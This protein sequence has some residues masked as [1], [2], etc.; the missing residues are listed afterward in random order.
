MVRS[1][2]CFPRIV[3]KDFTQTSPHPP[4]RQRPGPFLPIM[5]RIIS[6]FGLLGSLYLTFLDELFFLGADAFE[7]Y[8]GGLVVRIL[9]NQFPMNGEVK[10]LLTQFLCIHYSSILAMSSFSFATASAIL[11]LS[12]SMEE[13]S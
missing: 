13:T 4:L 5:G 3:K 6:R 12:S 10:N 11:L 2:K 1:I 7:E 9:G 8:G